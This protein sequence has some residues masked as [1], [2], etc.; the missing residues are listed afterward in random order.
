MDCETQPEDY[1]IRLEK[2]GKHGSTREAKKAIKRAKKAEKEAA[3]QAAR[4][5]AKKSGVQPPQELPARNLDMHELSSGVPPSTSVSSS[6]TFPPPGTVLTTSVSTAAAPIQGLAERAR[7]G[8]LGEQYPKVPTP[9]RTGLGGFT[10]SEAPFQLKDSPF[11]L[12]STSTASTATTSSA[13][14]HPSPRL[15]KGFVVLTALDNS[16]RLWTFQQ[17]DPGFTVAYYFDT[18]NN[19]VDTLHFQSEDLAGIIITLQESGVTFP[20]LSVEI[21]TSQADSFSG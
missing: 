21:E 14:T 18:V 6:T 19:R 17:S 13:T 12:T 3:K 20:N 7:I 16:N 9:D 4:G 1:W 11:H 8:L 15:P 2:R 5:A 10:S